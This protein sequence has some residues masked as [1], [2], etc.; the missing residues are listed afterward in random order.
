MATIPLPVTVADLEEHLN[1]TVGSLPV[2]EAER[3]LASATIAVEGRVGPIVS[4]PFVERVSGRNGI[5]AVSR[6]PLVSVESVAEVD[7]GQAYDVSVFDA[8]PAGIITWPGHR[9]SSCTYDVGYTAGRG[10][11][12]EVGENLEGAVL[13]TAGHL[14]ETQR[15][16][17][18]RARTLGAGG[19]DD[20]TRADASTVLRGFALPHRA[21]ELLQADDDLGIA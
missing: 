5:L 3:W 1:A 9:F 4:R 10:Q 13:I 17:Q 20:P 7:T 19:V 11:V 16:R 6:F 12:G 8:L 21:I 15:G 14:W 2:T 18:A